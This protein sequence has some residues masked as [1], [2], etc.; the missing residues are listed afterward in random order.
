MK[1]Q[2]VLISILI[3]LGFGACKKVDEL[4]TFEISDQTEIVIESSSPYS[5]PVEIPT[6]DITTNSDEEF[7]N[8]GTRADLVK[9]VYL[10]SLVLSIKSPEDKTFSFL[11]SIHIYI[12]TDDS[13]EIELAYKDEISS[14]TQSIKLIATDKRLDKY[15]K[16]DSYKLRTEVTTRETLTQDITIVVDMSFKVTADPL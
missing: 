2:I 6:P 13:D 10:S 16:A 14:D 7:S 3:A 15:V 5:L 9:D 4:L 8:N 1:L 12:R 11:K